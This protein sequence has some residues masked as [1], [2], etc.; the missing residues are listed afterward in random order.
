MVDKDIVKENEVKITEF[1][2]ELKLLLEKKG[3]DVSRFTMTYARHFPFLDL[4]VWSQYYL[5]EMNIS[6][7]DIKGNEKE[8]LEMEVKETIGGVILCAV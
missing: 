7:A 3:L 1:L 8:E 6:W 4:N 5:D 2:T